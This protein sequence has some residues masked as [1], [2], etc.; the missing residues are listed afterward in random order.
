MCYGIKYL[1]DTL[2][3]KTKQNRRREKKNKNK[4]KIKI[5]TNI[6]KICEQWNKIQGKDKE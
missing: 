3:V 6:V 4:N 5:K 1:K 2:K